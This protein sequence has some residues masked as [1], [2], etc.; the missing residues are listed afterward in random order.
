[1]GKTAALG[2]AH[3]NLHFLKA[4]HGENIRLI[5]KVNGIILPINSQLSFRVNK[6]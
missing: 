1:V 2:D 6:P 5:I 4:I 3:K